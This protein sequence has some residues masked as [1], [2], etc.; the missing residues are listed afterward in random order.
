MAEGKRKFQN[1]DQIVQSH[2]DGDV[3]IKNCRSWMP[4]EGDE[5]VI[6]GEVRIQGD[7]DILGTLKAGS[8][9]ARTREA[10]VI[11]GDLILEK[12]ARVEK[13]SLQ[14]RGSV[15]GREIRADASVKIGHDLECSTGSGSG[16]VKVGGN[17][18][19]ERLTGGGSVLIEGDAEVKEIRAGGSAKIHGEILS[20]EIKVGGS[21]KANRGKIGVVNVGGTF[22]AEGAIEIDEIEVGGSVLVGPGSVIHDID[23]GGSFKSDGEIKFGSIDVGGAVKLAGASSGD[24][25][26]V[27]G[28]VRVEGPL[29]MTGDLDVG[30]KVFVEGDCKCQQKIKVGGT[31]TVDGRIDTYRIIVG[32]RV[33]AKYIKAD[34]FRLGGRGE[35]TCFVEAREILVRERA[36]TESLYGEEIRIEE[37]TRTKNVYGKDIY[38]ENGAIIEGDIVYTD[39]LEMEDKVIVRGE[40]KKVDQ[41]PPV[42]EVD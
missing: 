38:I 3:D 8:L 14:V 29:E 9:H 2:I 37:R 17:A 1:E 32:G 25:I 26:D 34:G 6:T 12:S 10:I 21:V 41:L 40:Q 31:I 22:K 33:E 24:T 20:D 23:V 28:S 5:I 36:R 18:K 27:G 30:G 11:D 35:V 13:G 7:L 16:S 4:A 39:R 19:A 15:K 42:D